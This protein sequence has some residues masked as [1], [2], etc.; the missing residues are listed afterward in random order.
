M[1]HVEIRQSKKQHD[2]TELARASVLFRFSCVRKVGRET[3]QQIGGPVMS[4]ID[5]GGH[6]MGA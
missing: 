6:F 4:M 5:T 1:S 3:N 2:G